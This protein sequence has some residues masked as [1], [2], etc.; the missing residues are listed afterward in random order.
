VFS[1]GTGSPC[2]AFFKGKGDFMAGKN[3]V[4]MAEAQYKRPHKLKYGK[5]GLIFILPFFICYGVF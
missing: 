3:G 5:W 4:Q 1:G 2:S